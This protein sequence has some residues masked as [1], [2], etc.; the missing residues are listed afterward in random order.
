M[1]LVREGW[2][3]PR[4]PVDGVSKLVNPKEPDVKQPA[5][6]NGDSPK[7]VARPRTAL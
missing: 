7:S 1:R 2:L 5:M 3:Q 6:I 4:D